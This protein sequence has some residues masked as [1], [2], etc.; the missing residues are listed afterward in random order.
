[1][2]FLKN[3]FLIVFLGFYFISLTP[4]HFYAHSLEIEHSSTQALDDCSYVNLMN[5]GQGNSITPE[6]IF[7]NNPMH[8]EQKVL[9]ETY[10]NQNLLSRNVSHHFQLRAP[11]PMNV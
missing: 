2:N 7:Y 6:S 9:M 4:I 8:G 11:P 3:L 10:F 5:F 1:M